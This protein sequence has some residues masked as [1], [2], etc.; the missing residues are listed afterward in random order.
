MLQILLQSQEQNRQSQEH[1]T[2]RLQEQFKQQG[3]EVL[4]VLKDELH[5]WC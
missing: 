3:D 1:N 4:K 5:G 2:R